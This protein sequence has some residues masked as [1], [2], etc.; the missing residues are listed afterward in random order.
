MAAFYEVLEGRRLMAATPAGTPDLFD[1][2]GLVVSVT[3][4]QL[5]SLYNPG[6]AGDAG[7][8]PHTSTGAEVTYMLPPDA[9]EATDSIVDQ[10]SLR[11]GVVKSQV[12]EPAADSTPA[13]DVAKVDSIVIPQ[14][15]Y[16]GILNPQNRVDQGLLPLASNGTAVIKLLTP[17]SDLDIA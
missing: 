16:R 12:A 3:A 1:P 13:S 15:S 7:I 4:K 8:L 10:A 5:R 14:V 17:D 2:N 9:T 6:I 11:R